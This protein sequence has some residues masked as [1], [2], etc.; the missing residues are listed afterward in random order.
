MSCAG[1]VILD[2]GGLVIVA[3]SK[4][5]NGAYVAEVDRKSVV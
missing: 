1:V 5:L 3:S 2:C 4:V